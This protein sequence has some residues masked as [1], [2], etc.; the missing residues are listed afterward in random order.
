MANPGSERPPQ[1]EDKQQYRITVRFGDQIMQAGFTAV[2]NLLLNH[3]VALGISPTELVFIVHIWQYWWNAQDP[4]PALRTVGEKMGKDLRTARRYAEALKTK[5]LLI[6]RER[7]APGK[8]QITSEYDFAPLLARLLE[9]ASGTRRSQEG[10]ETPRSEMSGGGGTELTGAP[11]SEMSYEEYEG[12]TDP[13]EADPNNYSNQKQTNALHKEQSGFPSYEKLRSRNNVDNPT[14]GVREADD[15]SEKP[16]APTGWARLAEAAQALPPARVPET[17]G[18]SGGRGR[19]PK[20]PD[21]LAV[22]LE[23][24]SLKLND[25]QPRSSLT[26]ATKLWK[27]SGLPVDKFCQSV[28]QAMAETRQVQVKKSS[29]YG[30]GVMNRMPLFFAEL[31]RELGYRD[32]EQWSVRQAPAGL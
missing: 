7:S 6:V 27:A 31:E 30:A 9:Q 32:P 8:G 1:D 20:T 15:D 16:P 19:P 14:A 3:Y 24:A 17:V 12:E 21:Q 28:Y 18:F 10:S 13:S 2:P 11:R 4:Y 5:E 29:T 22:A 23:E 26:R 25:E